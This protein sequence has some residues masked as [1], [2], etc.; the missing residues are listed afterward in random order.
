MADAVTRGRSSLAGDGE[1]ERGEAGPGGVAAPAD[2]GDDAASRI[3]GVRFRGSAR[4]TYLTVG[5]L[6]VEPGTWIV[7]ETDRGPEVGRVVVAPGQ[8]RLAMTESERAAVVRRWAEDDV[9]RFDQ[10][11]QDEAAALSAFAQLLQ[12]RHLATQTVAAEGRFDGTLLTL[13]YRLPDGECW[14]SPDIPREIERELA[15]AL[16]GPVALRRVEAVDED[17]LLGGLGPRGRAL[18]SSAPRVDPAR[19]PASGQGSRQEPEPTTGAVAREVVVDAH[20]VENERY[21]RLKRA[22]PR[23][24]Q[25]VETPKGPGLVIALRIVDAL[26]TVRLREGGDEV[27]VAAG[28]LGLESGGASGSTLAATVTSGHSRESAGGGC[29]GADGFLD[30]SE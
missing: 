13:S 11:R 3:A 9:A 10:M 2:G 14:P 19:L 16:G 12:E 17:Y 22:L 23:L 15:S 24:G 4:L 21:K 28:D 1:R 27:V 5:P 30:S 20:S 7:V 26:V 25:V 18:G 6:A 29:D 8:V